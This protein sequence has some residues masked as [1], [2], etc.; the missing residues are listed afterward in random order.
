MP[1]ST[2]GSE[3]EEAAYI[4]MATMIV[5]IIALSP[6]DTLPDYKLAKYLERLDLGVN[7]PCGTT[8]A[9]LKKLV[10]HKYI[11]KSIDKSADDETVDWRVGPR[12]KIEIGN[13]GIQGL[14]AEVYGDDAPE[15]LQ[16]KLQRS[17]GVDIV[18]I[19]RNRISGAGNGAEEE[20]EEEALEDGDPGPSR[21]GG[22]SRSGR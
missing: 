8:E 9:L 7:T 6:N 19:N 17:L 2:S 14:V 16:K 22:R 10:E 12:G 3:N 1:V 21:T 15:D 18:K 4:G 5:S 13:K 20:E 11:Y